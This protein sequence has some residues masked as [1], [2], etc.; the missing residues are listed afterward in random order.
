MTHLT[1]SLA[2]VTVVAMPLVAQSTTPDK[3]GHHSLVYDEANK[4][5]LLYGGSTPL[6][7]GRSFAFF[8]DMWAFDGRAWTKSGESGDKRSG[9]GLVYDT[10]RNRIVSFGGYSGAASLSDFRSFDGK[11]WL[12]INQHPEIRAA[13]AGFVYDTKRDRFV[14][15]GGSPGQGS[16][17]GETWEYDNTSWHKVAGPGPGPRQGHVMVF[18][19]KR[20][21]VVLFGGSGIGSP[22]Q[23]P[24]SLGD[25]WEYDGVS[26]KQVATSGPSP[27]GAAGG[28][29]DAKRGVVIIFGGAGPDGFAGDTWSWDGSNWKK[30][31]D[32][33]PEARAMGYIAYDKARDRVVLFGGRK[34]WP[35]GDLNDTWEWDGTAWKRVGR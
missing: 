17:L 12:R 21:R 26:W 2:L 8:N 22:G 33:G 31:A 15:F 35:D 1:R 13:E 25:T 29:F 14:T 30:L 7:G 5:V 28:T 11:D 9:V 6:D 24:P 16:A 10:K 27:R 19:T 20:N 34:G 18:D 3:R 23:P 4:R 32:T